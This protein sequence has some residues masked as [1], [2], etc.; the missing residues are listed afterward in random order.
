M[1]IAWNCVSTCFVRAI[2]HH[3]FKLESS[4]LDQKNRKIFLKVPIVLGLIDPYFLGQICVIL[5]I[6]VYLDRFCVFSKICETYI[7]TVISL[8]VPH[9]NA[10]MLTPIYS[11]TWTT[12]Q[13]SCIYIV[14]IAGFGFNSSPYHFMCRGDFKVG[15]QGFSQWSTQRLTLDFA[16]CYGF[17]PNYAHLTCRYFIYQ[18][19]AIATVKQRPLAFILSILKTGASRLRLHQRYF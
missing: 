8:T 16:R 2:T 15:S 11:R 7:K 12:K 10:H 14:T 17:L 1:V 19:S 13:S 18:Q 5:P 3:T 9:P 4:N 6:Y